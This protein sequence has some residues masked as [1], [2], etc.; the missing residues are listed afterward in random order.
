V[1]HNEYNLSYL[2]ILLLVT[3]CLI[4][5][6]RNTVIIL[7]KAVNKFFKAIVVEAII[8]ILIFFITYYFLTLNYNYLSM[9]IM[10]LIGTLISFIAIGYFSFK[11]YSK[12]K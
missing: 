12:F 4:C 8:S 9:F 2:L 7:I 5:S 1:S 11:F 3:D 6:L 10:N